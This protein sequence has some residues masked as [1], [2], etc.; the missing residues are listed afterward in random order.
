MKF[1]VVS[2]SASGFLVSMYLIWIFG[3]QID[4]VKQPI[5][6]NTA[7]SGNVSHRQTF[8]FYDYLEYCLVVFENVKAKRRSE[9]VLR[10]W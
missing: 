10:L 1:S 8:A 7:S 9:K 4:S 2:M 6:R 5:E 3:V